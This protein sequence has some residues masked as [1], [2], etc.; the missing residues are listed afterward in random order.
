MEESY[1]NSPETNRITIGDGFVDS[2]KHSNYVGSNIS[3][4]MRDNYDIERSMGS[5]SIYWNTSHVHMF[6]KY[7]IFMA[8]S[9]NLLLW[10]C[11]S[12]AL[13]ESSLNRLDVFLYKSVTR[14]V[15]IK[16]S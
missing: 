14:V 4:H 15:R 7:I 13:N 3:Y 11:E 6:Y 10:G 5:F 8:I 9:V 16:M 1:E 12:R 2:T